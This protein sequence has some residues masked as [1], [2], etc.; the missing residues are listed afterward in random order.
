MDPKRIVIIGVGSIGERHLRCFRRTGR[1]EAAICEPNDTLRRAIAERYDVV[2]EFGSVEEALAQKPDAAVIATP[3]HLHV[4]IGIQCAEAGLDLLIEKPLS[5]NLESVEQLKAALTR[6]DVTASVAYT[7]RA[8]PAL[9]AMRN[10]LK[11]GRFGKVLQISVTGGQHF[12]TYR[13]AYKHTYYSKHQTGGGAIQD[14][15]PH[16]VNAVQWLAGPVETL[17]ADAAH[18][19]L[20]GV[21]VEDTVNLVARHGKTLVSYA[22][23]Q[24]QAPNETTI[25]A[26]CEF[27]TARFE[28]HQRRWRWM[29]TPDAGWTDEEFDLE[30]DDLYVAQANAFLD[31]IEGHA[32]PM[33]SIEEAEQTLRICL[34]AL[35]CASNPPWRP[36]AS[37]SSAQESRQVKKLFDLTGKTAL[38]TGGTGYLG[39]AM[40]QALAEAGCRVIVTSREDETAQWAVSALPS[41]GWAEHAGVA[42]NHMSEES[43]ENG[44]GQA[45][46]LAGQIDILV[47][48]AN[49]AVAKDWRNV[50]AEEFERQLRNATGYFSLAR[51]FHEQVVRRGGQGSVILLGSMYGMVGSYPD[52]YEGIQ[53]IS[54]VGYHALKGGI[55]Q[56]TRHLAVCWAKDGIRVNSLSPGPFP[57]PEVSPTLIE[58]LEVRCP[59]GRMGQPEELKGA[60]VFLASDASSYMTGQNL[61]IDGG[62][63]AW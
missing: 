17:F 37:I 10:A 61:V 2:A 3:A 49:E 11:T 62:W 48:N 45:M 27:G 21:N 44:F 9:R 30:R 32:L 31:C 18:L 40:A 16:L 8:H 22:L 7:Y 41:I 50:T 26:V 25:T 46:A 33:C 29:E 59:M 24:H 57:G 58:R 36:V 63:T 51:R 28:Y 13:P 1:V 15:V 5:T 53:P 38:F 43:L 52:V 35:D 34:G 6:N 19:K 39:P 47:N 54:P 55:L 20:E 12:P 23:N 14:M 60:I 4:P 56:M 42:L